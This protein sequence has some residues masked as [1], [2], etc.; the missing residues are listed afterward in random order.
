VIIILW[1]CCSHRHGCRTKKR[2]SE[3]TKRLESLETLVQQQIQQQNDNMQRICDLLQQQHRTVVAGDDDDHD[4][5]P[6]QRNVTFDAA[7]NDSHT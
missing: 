4:D 3:V 7:A 6:A 1:T 2:L 5:R